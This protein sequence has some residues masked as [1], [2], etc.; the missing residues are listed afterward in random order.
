MR[1][2]TGAGR[3]ALI[4]MAA[5][6]AVTATA[7]THRIWPEGKTPFFKEV[8]AEKYLETTDD[9]ERITNVS[10]PTVTIQRAPSKGRP[11]PAV[12]ICP[13]GGYGILAWNHEGID[14]GR[15]LMGRGVTGVLLKYRVPDQRDAALAD[16]QRAI[17]WVRAN[18]KKLNVDPAQVGIIG[19]SAGANLTARTAT[20]SGRR[21]Y[22]P[23]DDVDKLSCR[24]DF[25]MPIYPWE[26]VPGDCSEK[27]LPLTLRPEF[28]VDAKTPRAFIVQAEDDGVHVENG[29]AYYAALKFAGVPAEMHLFERGGHGYGMF[30][31]NQPTD[32]W[33][34]LAEVWLDSFLKK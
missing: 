20:N 18:A 4:G 9:I 12:V 19:F 27:R 16:A 25:Q 34:A 29:L 23:V 33:P 28:P 22:E 1:T 5:L 13:G 15:W 26:L 14:V 6:G 32:V 3:M 11:A 10:V 21:I 31:T 8:G 24:P 30:K 2:T 17:S 7:E